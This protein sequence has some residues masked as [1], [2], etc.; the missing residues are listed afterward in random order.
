MF[1]ITG[2]TDNWSEVLAM[3]NGKIDDLVL[4]VVV[5]MSLDEDLHTELEIK[6]LPVLI[7]Q[8]LPSLISFH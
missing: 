1:E 5:A 6:S 3:G 2:R 7:I 8:V 4:V